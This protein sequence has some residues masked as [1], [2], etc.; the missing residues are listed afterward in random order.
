MQTPRTTPAIRLATNFDDPHKPARILPTLSGVLSNV[1]Y[2]HTYAHMY[3][4]RHRGLWHALRRKADNIPF[5]IGLYRLFS[6]EVFAIVVVVGGLSSVCGVHAVGGGRCLFRSLVDGPT[7]W[8]DG[9]TATSL[10]GQSPACLPACLLTGW[11]ACCWVI[12]FGMRREWKWL[13][14]NR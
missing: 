7:D 8:M 2:I 11:L 4:N 9:W 1:E 13:S 3:T 5:S 14:T 6:F 12:E 10:D